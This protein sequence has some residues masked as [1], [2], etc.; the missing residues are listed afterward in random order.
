MQKEHCTHGIAGVVE[1]PFVTVGEVSVE[2][3]V[4]VVGNELVDKGL[5][6]EGGVFGRRI[7]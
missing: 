4:G 2:V 1:D 5:E 7:A 6:E 3:G